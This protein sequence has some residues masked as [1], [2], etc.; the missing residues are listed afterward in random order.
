MEIRTATDVDRAAAAELLRAA[1]LPVPA[2]GE[3]PVELRVLAG[4]GRI[5]ACAGFERHDE[6]A[7]LRSI[8][9][10]SEARGRSHGTEIVRATLARID[11][12]G[13]AETFLVTMDAAE[14][15]GRLGFRAVER[16]TVPTAVHAS[17]EW[18]LHLCVGG[19]WMRR[20]RSG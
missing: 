13:V 20:P 6:V 5:A 17:P 8:V 9:V 11:A 10:A 2:D 19:T 18:E 7:L 4:E 3:P 1:G 16:D 12:L 15:F 14:F